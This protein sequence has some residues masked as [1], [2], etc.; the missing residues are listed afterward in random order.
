M[1][2]AP[3]EVKASSYWHRRVL[4]GLDQTGLTP[5]ELGIEK[6]IPI[7][8]AAEIGMWINREG[9]PVRSCC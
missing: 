9:K 8:G 7:T 5:E 6:S 2:P 1:C 3:L 4:E